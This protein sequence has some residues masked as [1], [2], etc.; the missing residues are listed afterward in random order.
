MSGK[1]AN[2]CNRSLQ[3]QQGTVPDVSGALKDWF[4]PLTFTL[5]NKDVEAFQNVE[6]PTPIIFWGVIQPF[7]E[8]QLVLKPEGERSWSWL[9][10]HAEPS[11]TLKTDDVVIYLGKQTRVASRKDYSLY[12]YVEYHLVQDYVGAGP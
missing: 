11:C 12:G 6:D 3:F 10:M 8:R 1:I 4:Q 9:L 5:V 7:T 2:G